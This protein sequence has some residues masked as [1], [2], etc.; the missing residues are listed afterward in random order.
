MAARTSRIALVATLLSLAAGGFG[1]QS[2]WATVNASNSTLTRDL[3]DDPSGNTLILDV[4]VGSGSDEVNEIALDLASGSYQVMPVDP[5]G[6]TCSGGG[7]F[8]DCSYTSGQ[9]IA[10]GT[11]RT[12]KFVVNPRYPDNQTNTLLIANSSSPSDSASYQIDG[13]PGSEGGG[14][15]TASAGHCDWT[16]SFPVAPRNAEVASDV[17]YTIQVANAGAAPCPADTLTVTPEELGGIDVTVTDTATHVSGDPLHDPVNPLA[18]G[19]TQSISVNTQFDLYF[20]FAF[21]PTGPRAL[22]ASMPVDDDG[23]ADESATAETIFESQGTSRAKPP[24]PGGSSACASD[25]IHG[26]GGTSSGHV[27]K[28]QLAVAQAGRNARL[29]AAGACKWLR[30]ARGRFARVPADRGHCDR[31]VWLTAKGTTHWRFRLRGKLPRGRYAL[32]TRPVTPGGAPQ[33]GFSRRKHNRV[34]FK[35][36]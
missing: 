14:G 22:T 15:G 13:P 16:V 18:P 30:N 34:A 31:P 20:L 4:V 29:A 21:A 1:A 3:A 26:F 23:G 33:G 9:G 12:F 10:A 36:R 28:V 17:R 5:A 32:Y 35:V 27:R 2:A 6:P 24:C 11:H 8:L 25:S 19:A 7:G